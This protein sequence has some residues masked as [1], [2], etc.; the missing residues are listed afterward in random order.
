MRGVRTARWIGVTGGFL[1]ELEAKAVELRLMAPPI[2]HGKAA[3][4]REVRDEGADSPAAG[5]RARTYLSSSAVPPPPP[6]KEGIGEKSSL[7][8][9]VSSDPHTAQ[10]TMRP[11]PAQHRNI[12]AKIRYLQPTFRKIIPPEPPVIR[13]ADP[14]TKEKKMKP[15][16]ANGHQALKAP[17]IPR[18]QRA[19]TARAEHKQP[20][21]SIDI[22]RTPRI[23]YIP[24]TFHRIRRLRLAKE[25]AN[26]LPYHEYL[27]QKRKKMQ[28][29]GRWQKRVVVEGMK[30]GLWDAL[31]DAK[32]SRRAEGEMERE[33]RD[34]RKGLDRREREALRE[35]VEAFVRG[36][37]WR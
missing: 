35:D 37:G 24:R 27:E 25:S 21:K 12:V 31:A 5:I 7:R 16:T 8:Q 1:Q 17:R 29:R 14:S 32:P 6:I 11:I 2:V 28:S 26:R 36:G 30:E 22:V 4:E 18:R 13:A 15:D 19:L 9:H 34:G 33:K 20:T 3:A 10:T 23:N